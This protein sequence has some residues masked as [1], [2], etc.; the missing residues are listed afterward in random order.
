MLELGGLAF[1]TPWLLTALVTLPVL[2]WLL[3]ATPPAPRLVSFP[4]IRLILALR[5]NEETPDRTPWWLIL[6]RMIL[7]AMVI[8][9]LAHPLL[10]PAA[11]LDGSGP[12][13][14]V[15]DD[16]WASA[17]DWQVRQQK[18]AELVDQADRENRPVLILPTA[19]SAPGEPIQISKM[20]RAT[21][22]LQRIAA[23]A[24]KPWPSDR[25]QVLKALET[26]RFDGAA[27]IVWIADGIGDS[28]V[29]PLAS[30]LQQI[31]GV[32]LIEQP[33]PARARLILPPSAEGDSFSVPIARVPNGGEQTVQVRAVS[34]DGRLIARETATFDAN[35]SEATAILDLPGELRND[36]ARIEIEN[37]RN[38]G[39]V[40]LM[41]ERW[42]RRPVGLVSGDVSE[43]EQPLLS[44][45]YYL[46]RALRPFAEVR[47]GT[48]TDLFK[49]ELAIV[50]LAD[51]GKL[52]ESDIASLQAWME[53]GG[54]VLRF[55]GPKLASGTDE[56][57]PVP[58]RGGGRE[59]G[60][61]MS[62]AEPA[63]LLPFE[64]A[65]PFSGLE[66]TP[67]VRI[68]RQVL[69]E[70]GLD[71]NQKT[72]ARLSDGTPLVTAEKRG[73]GWIVLVHTT[74]NTDWSNLPLSG[75]FVDMLRRIVG[76]S[77]GVVSGD[78]AAVLPPLR[79]MDGYGRL[80]APTS[81]TVAIP[82]REFAD[83][84]PKP[85]TPPGYYGLDNGRRALNMAAALSAL[86][87][88]GELPQGIVRSGFVTA[89]QVDFKP[90]L[91]L[92]ALMLALVDLVVSFFLRGLVGLRG[93]GRATA[94]VAILAGFLV[95]GAPG[96][97]DAQNAANDRTGPDARA[98]SATTSTRLAYVVTGDRSLDDM[99][100][101][102]LRGLSDVL[103]RR[104]AVEPGDPIGVDIEADE[105]A[106]FP[107]LYWAV[108]PRQP[109]LSEK[110][111]GKLNQYLKT[112]GTILFDTRER[113]GFSS[114]ASG[115]VG[116]AGF[117]LR[118]LLE[119]LDVPALTHTPPDHVLTKAF[120]LLNDF[121]GRWTGGPLW[122]ERRG[123][124]HNDGVSSV[125]I[126]TNDFAGAWAV[127]GLGRPLAAVVPGGERQREMA[128]RFGVNWVM[129][130]LTGNYKTDQ[131]HVP[132]IIERLGQ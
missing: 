60:G 126:G 107:L 6:L 61:A 3:R 100:S 15:V 43:A 18:I 77:A 78:S 4:P 24:P 45:L 94:S 129:Y 29:A 132:A 9:A 125:I 38:A 34:D 111:R 84:R 8:V 25:A 82:A 79:T 36:V 57:I 87:P 48:V 89:P 23:L 122:V 37:G 99:T 103:R 72:W 128:Y 5:P 64:E 91:L 74:A 123:G 110:A 80:G 102:G 7:A 59:L 12:L 51:I 118:R 127:D 30:R 39:E 93:A 101:A 90:W 21:E 120:Y 130:A 52:L 106:F 104:T 13:V 55:A 71:L 113:G 85:E 47:R 67:D 44:S 96:S 1:T 53:K 56:M 17:A 28:N 115:G 69:A 49:R 33:A 116:E 31:G 97:A 92:G 63:R 65:S 114:D 70:P 54:V 119:G 41:D 50:V 112:G 2:W 19:P 109:L 26:I 10:N 46:E 121:P 124:R 88:M 86:A 40:F 58:L 76:L 14:V 42:R 62:W 68:S 117:H 16:G 131:V 11:K 75:L 27:N 22:A 32:T 105:L 83:A 66:V 73:R 95:A 20:M 35:A 108:S 81:D 98:L